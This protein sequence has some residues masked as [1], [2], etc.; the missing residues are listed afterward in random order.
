MSIRTPTHAEQATIFLPEL[1]PGQVAVR[2]QAKRFNW[3]CAGRRWRKTTLDLD[4]VVEKIVTSGRRYLWGAP[5]FRQVR[6]GWDE[7]RKACSGVFDFNESR[8]EAHAPGGGRVDFISL[9]DPDNARGYTA[10]GVIVDEA[11]EVAERA[12]YEILRPML[13]DTGGEAWFT[14]TP[15]GQNWTW[16]ETMRAL[17]GDAADSAAWQIPSKGC[18]I[19]GD[20]LV[21]R[22]HPLENPHLPWSELLDMF[23]RMPRR[24]F[25]QEIMAVFLDDSGGVFRNV[26]RIISGDKEAAPVSRVAEYVIGLDLAK[27]EDYTVMCIGDLRRRHMVNFDRFNQASWPLQ[28]ARIIETARRWNNAQVWMDATGLGDPIYDDLRRAGLRVMPYKFTPASKDALYEHAVLLVEQMGV[29]MYREPVLVDEIKA[30]QYVR[31]GATLKIQAPEGMHDD[32][33]TAFSLMCWPMGHSGAGEV[34]SQEALEQLRSP[35]SEVGGIR[36]MRKTF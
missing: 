3:L 32:C 18:E 7:M 31:A 6:I 2:Q 23:A 30:L 33:P 16:K 4:V 20:E 10:D 14:F 35:A 17:H 13:M 15:K 8:M 9:D 5:T 36:I 26:E 29:S 25:E 12:W 24:T 21:R 28:K 34:L 11:S 27:H 22:T 1:H 19:I